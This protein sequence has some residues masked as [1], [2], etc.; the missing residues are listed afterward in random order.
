MLP[1]GPQNIVL[2]NTAYE[3]REV[4][5]VMMTSGGV[6]RANVSL[7]NGYLSLNALPWADVWVDGNPVGTTPLANL[8]LAIGSHEVLWKHPTLGE[9]RELVVVKAKTPARAGVDFTR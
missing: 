1:V 6:T 2:A 9:R 4:V 5:S 7:P 8:S 3:Y